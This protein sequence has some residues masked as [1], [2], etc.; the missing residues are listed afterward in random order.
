MGTAFLL[1]NKWAL[2]DGVCMSAL[3]RDIA[4]AYPG[5]YKVYV[6]GHYLSHWKNNPYCEAVDDRAIAAMPNGKV[7]TVNL[8]YRDG[9]KEASKG[10]KMHFLSYFHTDFKKKTGIEV[11]VTEPKG[12]IHLSETEMI[13][14]L[15]GRYWVVNAGG[16]GDM[17]TKIWLTS[18]HQTVVNTL[19]GL[20]ITCAQIG[21]KF[22]RHYHPR[23]DNCISM[24]GKTD[25]IR[26]L[27]RLIK[28]SDGVICGVTGVMHVAAAF[29][30]PCVVI[31]GGREEPWWEATFGDGST[32]GPKCATVK[33]PH[34][35]LHTVGLLDCG[36]G[37]LT[38]GCWKDR[39][40]AIERSDSTN[41]RSRAQLCRKPLRLAE[42]A[43]PEC[44]A[45]ITP[46][47]VVEGV[48]SYYL[49]GT[50]PP[51]RQ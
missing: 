7:R 13:P 23:L 18:R 20:G 8:D 12:D 25:N 9:I 38:R 16:K 5:R 21:A 3:V 1:R 30:K 35:Y 22:A 28:Y 33:V 31:A 47:M 50:L 37:N 26:D 4:R 14:P 46:E 19:A 51:P 29:D 2:G 44:L 24:I 11:P 39:T 43:V 48:L 10:R 6:S 40:V 27:Y 41:E 42:Q 34:R 36:C 15:S 17:T 45:M 32:Y 49:D